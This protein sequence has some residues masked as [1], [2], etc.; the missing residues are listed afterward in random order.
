MAA[1]AD[2]GHDHVHSHVVRGRQV[3]VLRHHVTRWASDPYAL[4]TYS[5]LRPAGSEHDRREYARPIGGR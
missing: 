1:C 3:G 5:F 4:G 2:H